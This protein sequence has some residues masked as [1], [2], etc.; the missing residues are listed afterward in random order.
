MI[1]GRVPKIIAIL[2]FAVI[3]GTSMLCMILVGELNRFTIMCFV[4]WLC[5][6]YF[7]V[8]ISLQETVAKQNIAILNTTNTMKNVCQS[9]CLPIDVLF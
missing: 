3:S 6:C 5:K 2:N 7:L 4:F 9:F 8:V 1:S